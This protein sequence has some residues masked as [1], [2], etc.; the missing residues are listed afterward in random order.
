[1]ASAVWHEYAPGETPAVEPQR[2]PERGRLMAT[3]KLASPVER[4]LLASANAH[5]S[6]SRTADRAGRTAPA[7][8]AFE[9]RF[10][11]EADG[12]QQRAENLRRAYFK[13]L[14]ARSIRA[15]RKAQGQSETGDDL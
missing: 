3:K 14:A 9:R 4:S 10:L 7:R 11:K 1:L 6:W 5:M 8:A 13:Q 12:D 15:R 2:H